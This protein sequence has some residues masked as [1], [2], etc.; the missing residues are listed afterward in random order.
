M[1]TLTVNVPTRPCYNCPFLRAGHIKES[2][3]RELIDFIL[4]PFHISSCHCD[5]GNNT[6]CKGG[7]LFKEN[8][9]SPNKNPSIFNTKL[10]AWESHNKMEGKDWGNL[11][12]ETF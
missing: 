4:K 7:T 9:I 12:L 1:K 2:K 11:I 6:L 5:S 8:L 10:E 3:I